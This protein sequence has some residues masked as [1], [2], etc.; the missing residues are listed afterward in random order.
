LNLWETNELAKLASTDLVVVTKADGQRSLPRVSGAIE[1]S[2]KMGGGLAQ[3]RHA[4]RSALIELSLGETAAQATAD[5]CADSIRAAAESLKRARQLNRQQ[6]GEE[7]V[8]SELRVALDEL[9][10]VVGAVYTDDILDRVF[11]R[12]CIGK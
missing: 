1:T 8:G 12:F 4:M 6:A 3:L 7:L 5:R 9:G 11:S 2:A 10:K